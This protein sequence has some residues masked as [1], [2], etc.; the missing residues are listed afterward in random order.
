MPGIRADNV[1]I[2]TKDMYKAAFQS[3][4]EV[5]VKYTSIYKVVNGVEGAGHKETQLLGLGDLTRHTAENQK[6]NYRSPVQ[7]W[8]YLVK[9]WMWSDGLALSKEAVDD[10]VKLGNF[11]KELAG[12]WGDSIRDAK[13]TFAA[14]PFN[15]GGNLLGDFIFNGTHIGNTD[16]SGELLYDSKPLFNLTGNARTTKGGQT[17]FNSIASLTVNPGNF[18]T[19]YNLQTS[20][21]NRDELGRVKANPADTLLVRPGANRFLAERIVDTNGPNRSLPGSQ[22]NDKNVY[23]KIVSVIDWDYLE[24]AEGNMYVGKRQHKD[25]Q[26]HERQKPEIRFW[27]DETN[28]GYRASVTIRQGVFFKTFLAWT[29]GGGTSA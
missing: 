18:E 3:F 11:L 7:G 5:P 15:E 14:R 25:F 9:Y 28:V 27:R 10:N 24:S 21:N 16:S 8:P 22:M 20:T 1:A 23:Y 12:T 13:E 6:I 29:R 26:F 4:S 19:L 17:Y 2:Y